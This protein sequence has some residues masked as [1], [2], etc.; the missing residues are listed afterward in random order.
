MPS[1]YSQRLFSSG[2]GV[3]IAFWHSGMLVPAYVGRGQGIRVLI[4]QHTDGEYITRV[5]GNMGFGVVRG[6]STRGGARA[7]VNMVRE[8]ERGH[9]LAITPDGPRGPREK[10][11]SG[12]IFLAKRTGLPIL[13]IGLGFSS[14]WELPSWDRFRIPKPFSKVVLVFGE[15]ISVPEGLVEEGVEGYRQALEES[16]K[17]LSQGA[18][19]IIKGSS[20]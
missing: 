6:S 19:A 1:G 13:P 9:F 3:I 18:E 5:I 12:A 10:A 17:G 2:S 15:P 8:A 20:T 14:C 4:S 11:Q 7:M 16:L